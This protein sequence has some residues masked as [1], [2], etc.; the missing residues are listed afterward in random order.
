[1]FYEYILINT[2]DSTVR[3]VCVWS[4]DTTMKKKQQLVIVT[5]MSQMLMLTN[6]SFTAV[7]H[8]DDVQNL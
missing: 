8:T 1:M 4:Q 5:G 3:S 7:R 6:D 2:G